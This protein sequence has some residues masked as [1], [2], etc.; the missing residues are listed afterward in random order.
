MIRVNDYFDAGLMADIINS[1]DQELQI[2]QQWL[3]GILH[4]KAEADKKIRLASM[5]RQRRSM[6]VQT[7]L[8]QPPVDISKDK[9]RTDEYEMAHFFVRHRL[10]ELDIREMQK[11]IQAALNGH[12]TDNDA[13]KVAIV[14][15]FLFYHNI[16]IYF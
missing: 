6:M 10:N 3:T 12:L 16:S 8:G 7:A 1:Q 15:L 14:N 4:R 5:H 9:M 11:H 13:V 2:Q